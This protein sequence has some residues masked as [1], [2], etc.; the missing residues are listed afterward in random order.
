ME[1]IREFQENIYFCFI[2]YA[3]AFDCVNYNKLWKILKEMDIPDHLTCLLRIL[4]AGQKATVWTGPGTMGW[5][6][7]G[8]VVWQDCRLSGCRLSG[9]LLNLYTEYIMRNAGL[10]ESQA[11]IEIAGRNINNLRCI[12]DTSNGRNWGGTKE[13]LDKGERGELKSW[14]KTQHSK[15]LRSWYPIPSLIVNRR[16]KSGTLDRFY[17][18][19]LQNHCS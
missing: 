14:L 10:D 11:G 15:K 13:P 9:C 18:L 6:K 19:G 8:K 7:I 3:K 12:D 16:G 4:Y 5:F 2:D 17:F 1:K